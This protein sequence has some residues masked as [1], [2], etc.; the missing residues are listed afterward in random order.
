MWVISLCWYHMWLPVFRMHVILPSSDEQ[1]AIIKHTNYPKFCYLW[2]YNAVDY[3]G[4]Q[5]NL[6]IPYFKFIIPPYIITNELT[7]FLGI[8]GTCGIWST[9]YDCLVAEPCCLVGPRHKFSCKRLLQKQQRRRGLGG[10]R[11]RVGMRWIQEPGE[12]WVGGVEDLELL[13]G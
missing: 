13:Q 1:S 7:K 2:L 8:C 11:G 4:T 10:W 5:L 12:G 9:Q 6:K 3:N